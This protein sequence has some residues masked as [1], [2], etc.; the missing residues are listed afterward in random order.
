MDLLQDNESSKSFFSHSNFDSKL[1]FMINQ[2]WSHILDKTAVSQLIRPPES[3]DQ[4]VLS[5][6]KRNGYIDELKVDCL[7]SLSGIIPSNF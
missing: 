4:I 1:R 5:N 3:F 7:L 2:S 6:I